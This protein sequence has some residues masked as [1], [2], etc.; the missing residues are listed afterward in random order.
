MKPVLASVL[1][2]T[3]FASSSAFALTFSDQYGSA[4][5]SSY[6][7]RTIVIDSHTRY[8]NVQRGE[9]VTIRD[10]ANSIKWTFDGIGTAFTLAKIMPSAEHPVKVFVAPES[11]N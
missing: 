4:T 5:S 8:L 3:L 2:A 7:G 9:T 6:T 11:W 10:G 1:L